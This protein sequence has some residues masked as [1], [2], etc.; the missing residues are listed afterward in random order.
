MTMQIGMVGIDGVLL[1][2]DTRWMNTGDV[3][4]TS[5]SSKMRFNHAR[6]VAITCARNME[7]ALRISD[8]IIADLSS[9]ED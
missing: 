2:S 4:Q 1:A 5:H 3:R 9:D 8:N 6:T 7:N